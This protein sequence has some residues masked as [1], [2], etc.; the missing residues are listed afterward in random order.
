MMKM[1]VESAVP[2]SA[3]G[4][5]SDSDS[6]DM[7]APLDLSCYSKRELKAES[8]SPSMSSAY[9]GGYPRFIYDYERD[10]SSPQDSDDSDG[11]PHVLGI[12]PKAYKKSLMKR[13]LDTNG[14]V[15]LIAPNGLLE[16][17]GRRS[18]R[19]SPQR[20][21]LQGILNHHPGASPLLNSL[22]GV[23]NGIHSHRLPSYTSGSTGSLP[24]SPADSGVSDVD[25]SSSGHT[26]NDETKARLQPTPVPAPHTPN[27]PDSPNPAHGGV[28]PYLSSPYCRIS[29]SN[30]H[31]YSLSQQHLSDGYLF[32]NLSSQY[33]DLTSPTFPH[34]SLGHN[35]HMSVTG[36][37]TSPMHHGLHHMNS[38]G[39][40]IPTSVIHQAP[41]TTSPSSS[42]SMEEFYLA[43]LGFPPRIKKK[44][45]K[46]KGI[47][48]GPMKR[49]SREGSTTYLW[50]F[51]LKLL[52]DKEYCPR[53]IKWTNREKGIFKLVDSKAVSR[54]WGLHKNKP[55]MNYETMGRA[56]RYYYQRGILAKVDGQR[57]VYQFVDVPKDIIEIDCNSV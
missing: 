24:P 39:D 35:G 52:Q 34:H 7:C 26:S 29:S 31:P 33:C 21:L 27:T 6:E 44:S 41:A 5:H 16:L 53:Y 43:E 4:R 57:L 47:D 48:N 32:A 46:P 25:S 42:S 28:S 56:L 18:P 51:L 3:E 1:E 38:L 55:D 17:E 30:R 19:T 50:E 49:K 9:P 13:Y 40:S 36:A 22:Q 10:S 20:T 54:L 23:P 15:R 14:G 37:P 11:K 2:M 12:N 45:R 8:V